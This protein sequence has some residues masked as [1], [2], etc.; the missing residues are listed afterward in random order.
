MQQISWIPI[1]VVAMLSALS[2][3]LGKVAGS[4]PPG[5][6]A[7]VGHDPDYIVENFAAT[8]FNEHGQPRYRLSARKMIHYMDDDSTELQE[9][10]F[11]RQDGKA[12]PVSVSA[13]RGLISSEGEDV[14]FIG[15]VRAHR[16][17]TANQAATELSSEYIRVM[18]D[19][20]ILRTDKPVV[21]RQGASLIEASG[22]EIDNGKRLVALQGRVRAVYEKRK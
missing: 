19:A 22:V 8:A 3:W 12:V 11:E 17:A 20:D 7:K 21:L 14:Y 10:R 1:V 15:D 13:R 18:P 16:P 5:A 6:G 9:P 2:F 4:L